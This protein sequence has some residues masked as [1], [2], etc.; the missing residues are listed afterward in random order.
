MRLKVTFTV[1]TKSSRLSMLDS[2]GIAAG[3]VIKL[4]LRNPSYVLQMD[5]TI[6]AVDPEIAKEIYKKTDLRF[7]EGKCD[8]KPCPL[9]FLPFDIYLAA[10]A[11]YDSVTYW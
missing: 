7:I 6:V 1:L 3:C 11:L 8:N 5:E 10:M 4:L 9:P 2:L